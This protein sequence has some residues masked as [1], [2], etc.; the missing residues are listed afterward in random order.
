MPQTVASAGNRA[1]AGKMRLCGT[2]WVPPQ[3]RTFEHGHTH[4]MWGRRGSRAGC[5]TSTRQGAPAMA[6]NAPKA[7]PGPGQVP[8]SSS[9]G[10]QPAPWQLDVRLAAFGRGRINTFLLLKAGVLCY[11]VMAA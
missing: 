1:V 9:R 11:F 4:R 10:N 7:V 5:V 8:S 2:G 6:S 3:K